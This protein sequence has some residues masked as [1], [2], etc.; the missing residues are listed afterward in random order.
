MACCLYRTTTKMNV[1]IATKNKGKLKEFRRILEPLG[2]TVL[3]QLDCNVEDQA[4]E[5]GVSFEEN[6]RLKAKYVFKRTGEITIADDSGLCVDALGGRPGIYSARYGGPGL[7]DQD[8]VEKLLRELEG[9]LEEKRTA[10]FAC[11]V[12]VIFPQEEWSIF[13]ICEGKI[14]YEPA[15]N[16]GFGY[17]PVFIV[18]GKSFS[19]MDDREKD[20]VSH[21]GKALRE[22]ARRFYERER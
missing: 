2:F 22:L 8:R 9:T 7:T 14:G 4:E 20:A 15:G 1:V 3:S 18:K 10:H 12:S 6:A 21:R 5:N 11:A 17:D 19:E 16:G 13:E